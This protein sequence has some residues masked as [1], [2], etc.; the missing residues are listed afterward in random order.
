MRI[1]VSFAAV[2]AV[3]LAAAPASA[4]DLGAPRPVRA[5]EPYY[6]LTRPEIFHPRW[7]G[8]YLGGTLGL[9][10]GTTAADGG[11]GNFSFDTEGGLGTVFMGYNWQVTRGIVLGLEAD[12]GTGGLGGSAATPFG[13]VTSE[14]NALGSFRGRAGVVLG[15]ALMIYATAGLAWADLDLQLAG[16]TSRG[17][18]FFGYQLGAGADL[19]ISDHVG[20]RLE[21][22]YTDLGAERIIHG[23]TATNYD[24]DFHTLRAGIT[25]K[26]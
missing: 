1:V 20:L 24:P 19:A 2:L 12:I 6:D 10:F 23:G 22:I 11:L 21:Y 25:F 15:P 8:F 3:A 7:H 26:F 14:V 9:G 18:T 5:S 17:E 4:A 16:T 13:T